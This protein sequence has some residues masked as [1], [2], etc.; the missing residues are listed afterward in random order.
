[1]PVGSFSTGS[2]PISVSSSSAIHPRRHPSS[3]WAIGPT[4]GLG[5]CARCWLGL[6]CSYRYRLRSHEYKSLNSAEPQSLLDDLEGDDN[7]GLDD[8]LE[9][10]PPELDDKV[11]F[12][13]AQSLSPTAIRKHS[14]YP[15]SPTRSRAPPPREIP[16]PARIPR[17]PSAKRN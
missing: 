1:M 17:I 4:K 10:E 15:A 9:D 8:D 2:T 13:F 11:C 7:A 6:A 14:R 3:V 16:Y 12:A 5:T